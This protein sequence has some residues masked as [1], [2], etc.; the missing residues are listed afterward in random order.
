MSQTYR[1]TRAGR[2]RRSNRSSSG[3]GGSS[4]KGRRSFLPA[5]LRHLDSGSWL[6]AASKLWGCAVLQSHMTAVR[7]PEAPCSALLDQN[8]HFLFQ[9]QFCRSCLFNLSFLPSSFLPFKY[10]KLNLAS[11]NPIQILYFTKIKMNL[12]KQFNICAQQVSTPLPVFAFLVPIRIFCQQ[13]L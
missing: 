4:P 8:H 3:H 9:R 2:R 7:K 12:K 6:M 11:S 1:K 13:L 5:C 10:C